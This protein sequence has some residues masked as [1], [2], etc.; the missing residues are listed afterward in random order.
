MVHL[1]L[2]MAGMG[3]GQGQSPAAS[4]FAAFLPLIFMVAIFYW[5]LIRPQIKEK[6]RHQEMLQNLKRGDRVIT[7]SGIFGKIVDIGE[8]SI[9]LDVGNKVRIDF[10]K[11][12]IQALQ[13]EDRTKEN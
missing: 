1:V 12:A 8:Q 11:S 3:Q 9:A 2:A 4:G 5:L 10:L 13:E 7:T 6:R